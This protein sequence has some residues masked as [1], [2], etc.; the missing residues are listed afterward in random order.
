MV[1]FD[2]DGTIVDNISLAIEIVNAHSEVYKYK[3]VNREENGDLSAFEVVKF[4]EVKYWKLPYLMYQL[5]KKINERESEVKII[6]GIKETLE[7]LKNS[8]YQL[9][10]LT[11]N[12]S[13]NVNKFLKKFGIDSYFTYFKTRVPIFGKKQAL[14]KAGKQLNKNFIYVGD[15]IRDIEACRKNNI[16]II[17]VG[18][19]LNS[20]SALEKAN[21]GLVAKTAEDITKLI[22]QYKED[23]FRG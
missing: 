3:K 5:R 11:S 16:P 6:P 23:L 14:H 15:E 20:T 2:F 1:I 10:I 17:S 19:G 12:T 7:S 13:A 21:P 9:G 4:M 8:G 18:W 22:E